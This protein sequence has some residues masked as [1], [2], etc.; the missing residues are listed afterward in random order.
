MDFRNAKSIGNIF[1]LLICVLA[2]GLQLSCGGAGFS[3]ISSGPLE[4]VKERDVEMCEGDADELERYGYTVGSA[5]GLVASDLYD[6]GR[7]K[8]AMVFA[9]KACDGKDVSCT[10]MATLI[11]H[12]GTFSPALRLQFRE[13]AYQ[14]CLEN[15]FTIRGGDDGTGAVCNEVSTLFA[16]PGSTPKD[17]SLS[18]EQL[19]LG[20]TLDVEKAKKAS[21]RAC[22]H[23]EADACD[24][25][26]AF[27]DTRA[28]RRTAEQWQDSQRRLRNDRRALEVELRQ[29][30]EETDRQVR[31]ER[32]KA[33]AEIANIQNP[34]DAMGLNRAL[35]GIAVA[36]GLAPNFPTSAQSDVSSPQGSHTPRTSSSPPP[37]PAPAPTS[38]PDPEP[39]RPPPPVEP[40]VPSVPPPPPAEK[41]LDCHPAGYA[42][43][44]LRS[45]DPVGYC[46][47]GGIGVVD[48]LPVYR[49]ITTVPVTCHI[50]G[51]LG[52]AHKKCTNVTWQPGETIGGW[53]TPLTFCDVDHTDWWC[54]EGDVPLACLEQHQ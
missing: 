48:Y 39:Q 13:K 53:A 27:G 41:P 43:Q 19:D 6:R 46:K 18:K 45:L 30:D 23:G 16:Y 8:E 1:C 11:Q 17:A 37:P 21:S 54:Y 47:A 51:A 10:L 50:C 49:S 38:I 40:I 2:C 36:G 32:D 26:N 28:N 24:H 44:F 4:G 12:P 33:M 3:Q 31:A 7:F 20:L 22:S 35:N 15:E 34:N 25:A 29:M 5:C 14:Y 42:I 52:A 9:L